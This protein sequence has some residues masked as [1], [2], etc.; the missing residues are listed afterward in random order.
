MFRQQE[1]TREL[2]SKIMYNIGR[3]KNSTFHNSTSDV[4]ITYTI[5]IQF[6]TCAV[7]YYFAQYYKKYLYFYLHI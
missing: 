3:K 5:N 6:R 4:P 7:K 2:C 1:N